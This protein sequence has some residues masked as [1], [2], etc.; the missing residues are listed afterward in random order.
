M[1]LPSAP[2]MVFKP[3]R[4]AAVLS[5]DE[6]HDAVIKSRP[7]DDTAFWINVPF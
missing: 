2:P 4:L 7:E 1:P 6:H 3:P 5:D